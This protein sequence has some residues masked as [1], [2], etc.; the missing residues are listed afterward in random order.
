MRFQLEG[1][2]GPDGQEATIPDPVEVVDEPDALVELPDAP[3][4]VLEVPVVLVEAVPEPLLDDAVVP[5][6]GHA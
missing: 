5:R 3:E 1:T 4:A 6:T 2:C